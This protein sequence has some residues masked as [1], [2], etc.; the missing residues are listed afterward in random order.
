MTMGE[1][2]EE[3]IRTR[4]REIAKGY[5]LEACGLRFLRDLTADEWSAIGVELASS[6]KRTAW[7]IGDWL[8]HGEGLGIRMGRPREGDA[9]GSIYARAM[10]LTGLTHNALYDYA[11]TAREW[12]F[13]LRVEAYSIRTHEYTLR[14]PVHNVRVRILRQ[15]AERKWTATQVMEE[16][17]RHMQ[18]KPEWP[19]HHRMKVK[20]IR[21]DSFPCPHCGIKIDRDVALNA[22]K[23]KFT[24]PKPELALDEDESKSA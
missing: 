24:E 14:I 13:A 15:A 2:K 21:R 3:A 17:D 5:V 9:T 22:L 8:V 19:R 18:A 20:P 10:R 23:G 12:A 11:R 16:V 1:L 4:E 6:Y 7:A